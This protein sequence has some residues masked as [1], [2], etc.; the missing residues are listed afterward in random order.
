MTLREQGLLLPR[1][2]PGTRRITWAGASYPG[3]T[4][5]APSVRATSVHGST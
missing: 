2:K 3:V 5:L 1:R 4:M